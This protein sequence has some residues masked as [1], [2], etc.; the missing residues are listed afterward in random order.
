[1]LF[2]S[3]Y[4]CTLFQKKEV[5][6][7]GLR[8][9]D[10]FQIKISED[11]E[12]IESTETNTKEA[13]QNILKYYRTLREQSWTDNG[14]KRVQ[15]VLPAAD[16]PPKPMPLPLRTPKKTRSKVEKEKE[17]AVASTQAELSE[18][19]REKMDVQISQKISMKCIKRRLDQK[20]CESLKE[21]IHEKCLREGIYIERNS[22]GCVSKELRSH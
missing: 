8:Q 14:P 12:A 7:E 13:R 17:A 16:I 4:S 2:V 6:K 10:P 11:L 5:K 9:K 1:M 18:N 19:E 21:E 22:V 3:L 20:K 15:T